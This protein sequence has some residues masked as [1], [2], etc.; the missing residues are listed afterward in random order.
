MSHAIE[1]EYR[2]AQPADRAGERGAVLVM[3]LL[4]ALIVTLL[5]MSLATFGNHS[6]TASKDERQADDALVV[7]DAGLTHAKAILSSAVWDYFT[8]VL[9][10]GDGA[11]CT[12]DELSAAP[13][14]ILTYPA[15]AD[16]IPA[17]GRQIGIGSYRVFV[18]DDHTD[19]TAGAPPDVDP[20][21]DANRR[22]KVRSIGT[23][24]RGATVTLEIRVELIDMP[25]LV[26]DGDLE[27]NGSQTYMGAQGAVYAR[28]NLN[29]PGGPCAE[30]Y[31]AAGGTITGGT[32][33]HGGGACGDPPDLRP[34]WEPLQLPTIEPASFLPLATYR[35]GSDGRVRN[36]AGAVIGINNWMGWNWMPGQQAWRAGSTI[37]PGVYYAQGSNISVI[38]SPPTVPGT[39][40]LTFIADGWIDIGGSPRMTPAL[41]GPPAI[42]MVSGTDIRLSGSPANPFQGLFYAKDQM[43]FSGTPTVT[44]QA[45][46]RNLADGP[47]PN[48]GGSNLVARGGAG[49]VEFNG[50][51]ALTY[52]GGNLR[53]PAYSRWRECR[54][55][56]ANP[57]G[58]S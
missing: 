14:G 28:G 22:V 37:L 54:Q 51:V 36:S 49:E 15:A 21:V 35:M 5:G 6:L 30:Q 31:F 25:A 2:E 42:S 4:I 9:Q 16:L 23:G 1:R 27:V 3:A 38:G 52:A 8:T 53:F 40:A 41:L 17:A 39:I 10:V 34:E 55:T 58:P 11:G 57:C 50:N 46:V 12:G 7:A 26:V 13:A 47:Y 44:G 20:N 56:T 43:E 19:E 48:P 32:N 24:V 18:C 33:A 29:L 45:I